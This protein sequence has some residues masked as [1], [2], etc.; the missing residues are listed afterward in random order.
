MNYIHT[1]DIVHRDLKPSN[2]VIDSDSSVPVVKIIDFGMA[3]KIKGSINDDQDV[4]ERIPDLTTYVQ[5]RAYRAPEL[6]LDFRN[7]DFIYDKSIDIWSFGLVIIELIKGEPLFGSHYQQ[8]GVTTCDHTF[9][10]IELLGKIPYYSDLPEG[11]RRGMVSFAKEE[12]AKNSVSKLR[13]E[14]ENSLSV[15]GFSD[16]DKAGEFVDLISD[17]LTYGPSR[18]T[19]SDILAHQFVA[20]FRPDDFLENEE[21]PGVRIKLPWV[22]G[23]EVVEIKRMISENCL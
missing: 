3:R 20:D 1:S 2:I 7:G 9:A 23:F 15:R 8:A 18:V 4:S 6:L 13:Q 22:K 14:V 5:A 19:T 12:L 17:L 21:K 10:L 11:T 16:D